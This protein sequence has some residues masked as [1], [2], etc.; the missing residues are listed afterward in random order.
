MPQSV[1]AAAKH[2]SLFSGS[3]LIVKT[4]Q[5]VRG[6]ILMRDVGFITPSKH[7]HLSRCLRTASVRVMRVMRNDAIQD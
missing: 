1:N 4:N 2:K 3:V 6:V 7:G 5:Y